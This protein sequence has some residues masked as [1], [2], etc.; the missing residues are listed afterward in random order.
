[1]RNVF[2]ICCSLILLSGAIFFFLRL[3]DHFFCEWNL[4]KLNSNKSISSG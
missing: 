2:I 1:M 3:S 4:E